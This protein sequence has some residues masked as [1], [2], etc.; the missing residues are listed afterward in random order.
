M[1]PHDEHK[2]I[3]WMAGTKEALSLFPAEVRLQTGY[4]LRFAQAGL[5]HQ[6]ARRMRHRLRDVVEVRV[7]D[8]AGTFRTCYMV[9][10]GDRLYVLHAFQKKAK[11]GIST[12]KADLVL[13]E[14]RL[15]EARALYERETRETS[16]SDSRKR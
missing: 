6:D 9:A 16:K 2:K 5:M 11:T 7:D 8:P 12:P 3:Y 15:K 14:K 13:I 1:R 4:A 10:I